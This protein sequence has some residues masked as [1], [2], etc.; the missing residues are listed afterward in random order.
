MAFIVLTYYAPLEEMLVYFEAKATCMYKHVG[1]LFETFLSRGAPI[2]AEGLYQ[3]LH[4]WLSER[5]VNSVWLMLDISL[6]R[7]VYLLARIS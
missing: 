1:V 6:G 5:V 3:A 4:W 7:D 2:S